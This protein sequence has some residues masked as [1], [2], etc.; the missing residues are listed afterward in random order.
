MTPS[1]SYDDRKY[2]VYILFRETNMPFYVGKGSGR[3]WI[4]H[5]KDAKY[6]NTYK[7]R[8]IRKMVSEGHKIRR[9]KFTDGL[10]EE[11]AFFLEKVLIKK[12][13]RYPNGPLANAT[14]GG[15]GVLNLSPESR[16][17]IS[18]SH[19]GNQYGKGRK[20]TQEQID[21]MTEGRRKSGYKKETY[22][23]IADKLRGRKHTE[24]HNLKISAGGKGR[25]SSDE[26]RLKLSL[27]KRRENLSEETLRKRSESQK[28][29]PVS[30]ESRLKM[31]ESRLRFVENEN[32]IP[33]AIEARRKS[34][35][36]AGYARWAKR[37]GKSTDN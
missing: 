28:G 3:R 2:Y 6:G 15:D 20:N 25:K 10:T 23:K 32:T 8:I 27:C 19:L 11:A 37:K 33:G 18:I 21:A 4:N 24:E 26:T 17:K 22:D 1:T 13:G 7:D 36:I 30:T 5:E 14:D 35:S 9:I 29:H 16:S 34:A 31:R 12:I